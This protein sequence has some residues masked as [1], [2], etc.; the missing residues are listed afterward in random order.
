MHHIY[1]YFVYIYIFFV[2]IYIYCIHI[3]IYIYLQIYFHIYKYIYLFF[4]YIYIHFFFL[5]IY[6]KNRAC[7]TTWQ[8]CH[9]PSDSPSPSLRPTP[10]SWNVMYPRRRNIERSLPVIWKTK[11][12]PLIWPPPKKKKQQLDVMRI[13]F[14]K[15]MSACLSHWT[16]SPGNSSIWWWYG[17]KVNYP[18]GMVEPNDFRKFKGWSVK[19]WTVSKSIF[20]S[21]FRTIS[22][23]WVPK[24]NHGSEG[25]NK[26]SVFVKI[27]SWVKFWVPNFVQQL[28][29]L[30]A[31]RRRFKPS[32]SSAI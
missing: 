22:N 14:L 25:G 31:R 30:E 12:L 28:W 7:C 29:V 26:D 17:L 2:Y 16:F 6:Q 27:A 21:F 10:G 13:C 18:G 24:K 11:P 32:K 20:V 19:Q 8:L 23:H 9:S 4:V 1:I 15:K 3:Y 5:N